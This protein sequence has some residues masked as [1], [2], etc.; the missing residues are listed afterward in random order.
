MDGLCD[1]LQNLDQELPTLHEPVIAFHV[2]SETAS[3]EEFLLLP[4]FQKKKYEMKVYITMYTFFRF[5]NLYRK[6]EFTTGFL[7]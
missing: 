1:V 4:H 7:Q 6:L 5:R 3:L 2:E